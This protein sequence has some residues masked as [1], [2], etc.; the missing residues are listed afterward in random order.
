IWNPL[1]PTLSPPGRGSSPS[2]WRGSRPA[3]PP[4]LT[5]LFRLFAPCFRMCS[6]EDVDARDIRASTTVFAGYAVALRWKGRA[7][8]IGPARSVTAEPK[9]P[10]VIVVAGPNGAGKSTS[11]HHLLRDTLE[12]SEFVN[13]DDIAAGLSAFRPE[14]VAVSAGRIMLT[15]MRELA[16]ARV[17]F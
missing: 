5:C 7:N 15:R 12:V 16:A 2:L 8:Q 3:D 17:N 6:K 14:T 11:A 13:A 4:S 10:Y 9:L 1:T